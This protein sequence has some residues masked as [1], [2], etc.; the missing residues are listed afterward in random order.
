MDV[1]LWKIDEFSLQVGVLFVG[2]A[3]LCRGVP[4]KFQHTYLSSGYA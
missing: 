1:V 2:S 4:E 3:H